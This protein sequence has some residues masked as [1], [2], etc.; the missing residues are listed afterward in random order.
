MSRAAFIAGGVTG[1]GCEGTGIRR[2]YRAG[3]RGLAARRVEAGGALVS[4]FWPD[5]PPTRY[6]LPI[7]NVVVS[8]MGIGT[9]V[10]EAS[11][12]S[13]ARMQARLA[14]D[15]ALRLGLAT[16]ICAERG[17]QVVKTYYCAEGFERVTAGCP[18]PV[19][20]ASGKKLPELDALEMAHR[21]IN[22]GAAGVDMGRNIFQSE[23]PAAM[24]R[25][26]GGVVHDGLAPGEAHDLFGELA[27][28]PLEGVR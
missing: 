5:A 19:V 18:V 1:S 13:G 27:H 17:G 20:M 26:V 14:L 6:T 7:R 10:V 4:Q 11:S 24:L 8:G 28:A 12:T 3:K 15:Q 22:E 21:A 25:A 2:I 23:A 9:V 16:R